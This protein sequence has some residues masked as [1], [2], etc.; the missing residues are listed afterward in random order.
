M[1]LYR[2]PSTC[3][4]RQKVFW[5][6]CCMEN[7]YGPVFQYLSEYTSHGFF[8]YPFTPAHGQ[9]Q[10]RVILDPLLQNTTELGPGAR[11]GTKDGDKSPSSIR[12]YFWARW[13]IS[14]PGNRPGR[15]LVVRYR[16]DRLPG[17]LKG[18]VWR[19]A[20][21]APR[22]PSRPIPRAGGRRA[23]SAALRPQAHPYEVRLA[24]GL[25]PQSRACEPVCRPAV[26]QS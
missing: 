25:R 7:L 4:L 21:L 2:V 10:L 18:S 16:T 1:H 9:M 22:R 24:A 19:G 17:F 13:A 5:V 20:K 26:R 15:K 11:N 23:S 8:F 12:D 3:D 6:L 14:P